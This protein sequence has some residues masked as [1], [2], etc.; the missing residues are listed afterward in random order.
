ML[1]SFHFYKRCLRLTVDKEKL[2]LK[3]LSL[4]WVDQTDQLVAVVGGL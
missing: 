2:Q 3:S 1:C 4:I